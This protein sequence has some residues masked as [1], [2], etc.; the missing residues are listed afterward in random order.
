MSS[1]L[2]AGF[3]FIGSLSSSSCAI[4]KHK[5]FIS[6]EFNAKGNRPAEPKIC[7]TPT[8]QKVARFT[9]QSMNASADPCEDFYEYAC[10]GWRANHQIL[11]NETDIHNFHYLELQTKNIGQEM[12][13]R[14]VNDSS[15]YI[16][17]VILKK[18][19]NQC[20]D[21]ATINA[22]RAK[23]LLE[24]LDHAIAGW[25][26]ITPNWNSS[27]FYIHTAMRSTFLT[28]T[29]PFFQINIKPDVEN[30]KVNL[31]EFAPPATF[32]GVD[33]LSDEVTGKLYTE[34]FLTLVT[35]ITALLLNDTNS[36]ASVDDF[37]ANITDLI[38]MER[39]FGMAQLSAT[40]A[41]NDDIYLNKMTLGE[42]ETRYNFNSSV[43][44]NTTHRLRLLFDNAKL[45][46]LIHYGT[47]IVLPNLT[48]FPKLD[49]KLVEF[50]Q[51]GEEGTRRLATYIGWQIINGF[52]DYLN[53]DYRDAMLAHTQRISGRVQK[54][55]PSAGERCWDTA[56]GL[57]PLAVGA[58]Y[59]RDVVQKSVKPKATQ[60]VKDIQEG[61]RHMLANER[62][63]DNT[64]RDAAL[65][66]LAAMINVVAYPSIYEKNISLVDA[67]YADIKPQPT[68]VKTVM[69]ILKNYAVREMKRL[70]KPNQR[71][72]PIRDTDDVTEVNAFYNPNLN[73]LMIDAAILQS[74][75]Y[76]PDN[77]KCMNYGGIGSVIGHETT[78]GFDNQGA[79][80]DDQGVR[81]V[82]WTDVTQ[83]AYN[84][85]IK[86]IQWQ[87]GNYTTETGRVN[88]ELTLTENIA[89]NGGMRAA[90][91]GY[92][93]YSRR[94]NPEP[95]LPGLENF[96]PDQLFF[97]SNAQI[98]CEKVR[99]E[100]QRVSILTDEHSPNRWRVNG[101][102]S[103]MPE[104][105][106][107]FNCSAD[108][109]MNPKSKHVVW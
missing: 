104:F 55:D 46:Y 78:H 18:F 40:E 9:K 69:E 68:F 66:K 100:T 16:S 101:M 77:L 32:A 70:P 12:L 50:E 108:A 28:R 54:R 2:F 83:A 84:E 33:I 4:L 93:H 107:A 42:F 96:G 88:G 106:Q 58:L 45:G 22:L 82:W 79:K 86:G 29:E 73:G 49:Q 94:S 17:E 109:K 60:M 31:L 76:L 43:F 59:V 95:A 36:P 34:S 1:V 52:T 75:F 81:R 90:Y 63:M 98:W 51:Q 103:N 56:K 11:D 48:F 91:E 19:F 20:S 71:Y 44:R 105:A 80:Y 21:D 24:L 35:N 25:P 3:L 27:K 38:D 10:G 14:P 62:W 13:R 30:P 6:S 23:P 57:M 61:Y 41:N 26:I 92:Q 97:L 87:Y 102:V 85:K 7:E 15:S 72:D 64:T 65:K 39:Q 37:S 5:G 67:E 89:D 99:I 8:C 74:P 47:K 53:K